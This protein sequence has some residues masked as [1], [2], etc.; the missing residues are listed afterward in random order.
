[1]LFNQPDD[2]CTRPDFVR[3]V[4]L[5]GEAVEVARPTLFLLG[6][7]ASFIT[8]HTLMVDGGYCAMGPEGLG[9]TAVVAGSD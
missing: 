9:E 5:L 6:D 4:Q 8:G 3:A 7:D 2:L 1:L